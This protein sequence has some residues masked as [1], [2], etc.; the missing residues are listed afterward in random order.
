MQRFFKKSLFYRL[1]SPSN[2]SSFLRLMPSST[3]EDYLKQIFLAQTKEPDRPVP[4][5]RVAQTLGVSPGTA[6]T[7]VKSMADAGYL[8][9][10]PRIGVLLTEAG[11]TS[12]LQTLR[13]HRIL[14]VFL[15]NKLGLNWSEVHEEAEILEHTISE[16]VLTAL[17]AFLGYPTNDPHGS[18]I[19]NAAGDYEHPALDDLTDCPLETKVRVMRIASESS[20][21]LQFIEESGLRPGQ[22]LTVKSRS[23]LADSITLDLSEPQ[24]ALTLGMSVGKK[25]LVG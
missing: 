21:F 13:R 4:M 24:N 19:P 11:R 17:D 22:Q 18:P 3:I 25:I 16:R 5:G 7:M 20:E 23:T 8:E 14:E 6:T 10:Q 15:V 1:H 2:S 12:A 9:Y